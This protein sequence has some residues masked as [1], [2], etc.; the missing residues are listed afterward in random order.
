M[1]RRRN[2][3]G[4]CRLTAS[5][6]IAACAFLAACSPAPQ[7]LS[8]SDKIQPRPSVVSVAASTTDAM[9]RFADR[10][11]DQ[12]GFEVKLNAGPSN[13][14]ATQILAGA[15]ADVFLSASREWADKIDAAGQA[16]AQVDLLTNRLVVV[17]PR[18]NPAGVQKPDDLS[19]AAVKKLALAGENV[20]AGMYADQAL[21]KLGL[22]EPLTAAGK[23]VRGQDVR[24][25]LGY[26]ERGE[27][28]A[29]IV[30]A[31]DL[32]AASGV[33]LAYAFDPALHE[34]I[35][36]V[37]VLIKHD[38]ANPVARKFYDFL[39]SADA[40]Q[41]FADLGFVPLAA[42]DDVDDAK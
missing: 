17:V 34:K 9:E 5:A 23:I 24:A 37:L 29:G 41:V 3:H 13:G 2:L 31:S 8:P 32:R 18:G 28:E 14:L 16:A 4:L 7:S 12:T 22:L 10:F 1:S 36:Y 35:V 21:T 15:P 25:A 20:P 42:V 11:H 27:A 33:E 26:V 39:Q 40:K 30:Y 6:P 19:S 38:A